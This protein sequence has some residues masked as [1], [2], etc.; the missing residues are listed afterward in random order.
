MAEERR[1]RNRI[2][3]G[4]G[5]SFINFRGSGGNPPFGKLPGR[6]ANVM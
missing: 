6:R 1:E 5:S 3:P 2:N 4:E